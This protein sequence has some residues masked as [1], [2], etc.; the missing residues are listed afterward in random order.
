M[1]ARGVARTG[2]R[3]LGVLLVLVPAVAVFVFPLLAFLSLA[4]SP[5]LLNQGSAWM[6]GVNFQAALHGF[7]LQGLTDTAAV[8]TASA[9]AAACIAIWLAFLIDRTDVGG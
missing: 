1:T 3:G 6:T 8:G 9:V 2:V 5:R 7:M 4:P